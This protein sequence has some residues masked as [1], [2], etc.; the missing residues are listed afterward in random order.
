MLDKTP[1]R[2]KPLA[3][4]IHI[5]DNKTDKEE[6][7]TTFNIRK[8]EVDLQKFKSY[9]EASLEY[10][11]QQEGLDRKYKAIMNLII[12]AMNHGKTLEV[13]SASEDQE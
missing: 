12:W 8:V 10:L 7:V 11:Q 1:E 5:W 9:K 2:N 3:I 13:I 6:R 4:N